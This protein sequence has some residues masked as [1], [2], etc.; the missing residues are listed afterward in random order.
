MGSFFCNLLK[1]F[2][3]LRNLLTSLC[4]ILRALWLNILKPQIEICSEGHS[5][6][7]ISHLDDT[8]WRGFAITTLAIV[9][10]G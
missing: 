3:L 9:V 5:V 8:Y 10:I 4:K 1:S 6:I 7:L 2:S